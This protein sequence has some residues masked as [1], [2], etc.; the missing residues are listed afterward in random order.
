MTEHEV[1]PIPGLP[2]QLPPGERILWQGSPDRR[3]LART[4]F[5]IP[6]VIGYFGAL[7]VVAAIFGT[8]SGVVT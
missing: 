7:A 8:P 5:R 6:L 1:E 4:A 2:G 3:V